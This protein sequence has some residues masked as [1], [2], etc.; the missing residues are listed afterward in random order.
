MSKII[1]KKIKPLA[2][3]NKEK[4][5]EK[6]TAQGSKDKLNLE[7]KAFCEFF[8]DG[9]KEFFGNGVQSYIEVYNPDKD[10]KNWYKTSCASASRLLSKDNVCEYINKLLDAKGYND[11][12]IQK[13]HLFC[14]N[15][16]SELGVKMK[17]IA[18]Y[19]KVTG[20]Y[21]DDKLNDSLREIMK[22]D[23]EERNKLKAKKYDNN[24]K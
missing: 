4:K 20:K 12:N 7:Q 3:K 6:F 16:F 13:Q 17:A 10:N 9:D 15:Q 5:V 2:E 1:I 24:T 14:I 19:N 8:S 21:S 18:E 23:I 22:K 11:E